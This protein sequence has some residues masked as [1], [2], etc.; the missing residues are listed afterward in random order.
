MKKIKQIINKYREED[1]TLLMPNKEILEKIEKF[2][3]NK[4]YMIELFLGLMMEYYE[5]WDEFD[6]DEMQK[7]YN[8][9]ENELLFYFGRVYLIEVEDYEK[10]EEIFHK[11]LKNNFQSY[12]LYDFLGRI[13]AYYGEAEK[14]IEYYEQSLKY[15]SSD[16]DMTL[17]NLGR[18]YRHVKE[19]DRAV[20]YYKRV[21]KRNKKDY[22]ANLELA[23]VYRDALK[24]KKAIKYNKIGI[25]INNQRNLQGT[26]HTLYNKVAGFYS[27]LGDFEKAVK[28]YK[29]VIDVNPEHYLG[30]YNLGVVY[31][32]KDLKEAIKW[33]KKALELNS[34][35]PQY[36]L[37]NA[38]LDLEKYKKAIRS[39]KRYLETYGENDQAYVN[40]GIAYSK[41][42]RYKKGFEC[43]Y[44]AL[45]LNPKRFQ[46]Y[47]NI[48]G[49]YYDR[50]EYPP[51]ELE[52][53]FLD[54]FKD[55]KDIYIAYLVAIYKLDIYHNKKVDLTVFERDFK[56]NGMDCCQFYESKFF[57][58]T[59]KRDRAILRKFLA[60]LKKH[61]NV[62]KWDKGK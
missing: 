13:Y 53:R 28:F 57:D 50:H 23:D 51:K 18:L 34:T 48:F 40:M 11:L 30:Y 47:V 49:I 26:N 39:Y 6:Y 44:K 21:L 10:A 43:Y 12:L 1:K 59:K 9:G 52:K 31:H 5:S 42:E 24:Y 19:Y 3:F 15:S 41:L 4:S 35:A 8:E 60:I 56:G 54:Y 14:A 25:E 16:D 17:M 61:T 20:S 58:D 37:G 45:E 22:Y 38:Y 33:Y 27:K 32:D 29:K 55:D 7:H 2:S 36:N 62:I 46:A